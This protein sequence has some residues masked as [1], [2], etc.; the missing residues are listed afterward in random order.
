[1]TAAAAAAARAGASLAVLGLLLVAVSGW[2]V[3]E[4]TDKCEEDE[5]RCD[6]GSCVGIDDKCDGT[7]HCS[8]ASD[9]FPGLCSAPNTTLFAGETLTAR[10]R[11]H[12]TFKGV[13]IQLCG[14]T[15]CST[16][17]IEGANQEGAL[18][19]IAFVNCNTQGRHC[20]VHR[21]KGPNLWAKFPAGELI[22][23]M[24]HRPSE[25]AVWL[26]GHHDQAV[27]VPARDRQVY[28]RIVPFKWRMN[29]AV[30][31]GER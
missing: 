8:D 15:R 29:M 7:P 12:K 31:F 3:P 6:D 4:C 10:M 9:E 23:E 2:V 20:K 14:H 26:P 22:L 1:M 27:T 21:V 11:L 16:L 5:F 30:R 25:L 24:E 19:H 18:A 28:L 13:D 17:E